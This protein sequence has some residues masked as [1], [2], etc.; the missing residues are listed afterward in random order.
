M[1]GISLSGRM[2]S[3]PGP[4]AAAFMADRHNS[5][6]AL[7]GPVGGG[8]TVACIHDLLTNAA[9]MPACRD[10]VIRFRSVAIRDT[11]DRL[12]KTTIATWTQ[13]VPK[14]LG[15]WVGGGGRSATHTLNFEVLRGGR[16]VPVEFEIIFAAIGDQAAEDFCRGFEVTAC[17]LN[18]M[19]RLSPDVLTHIMGRI[20]RYPRA[21]MMPAGV[22]YREFVIGDL[23]AP[24]IDDWFYRLFEETRP[25]GYA[26]YKQPSGLSPQAENIQNLQAGY[27]E[28]LVTANV[29]N[30]KWVKRFVHAAYGPSDEGEPVYSEYSDDRHL[31]RVRLEPRKGVPIRL[32]VD[33]GIQRPAGV[34]TQWLPSGQWRILGEVVPGRM[35]AKRFAGELKRWM[36]EN[37]P[38]FEIA[39]A[40]CDPAGFAGGDTE[41]GELA[42]AETVMHELGVAVLPAPSNEIGLRLDAVRE[43]L[44]YQIDGQTPALLLSSECKMLRKGFASHY[45]YARQLVAGTARYSDKPEKNDFSHCHDALQ[46]VLLGSKGR[47]GVVAGDGTRKPATSSMSGGCTVIKNTTRL[48]G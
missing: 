6:R 24:D 19:D 17:W 40:F 33:A 2:F 43:E 14:D 8:K 32:G 39:Q 35:G 16:K 41:S 18:E 9:L 10:G 11:Y 15:T 25:E 30:P 38:G 27:Y 21:E 46:Y 45:R 3:A 20:G 12:E 34:F 1:T 42:W 13:W 48:F 23:N 44:T 26:I 7:L 4:V 47:Y 31:S 22:K 5:V 29:N 37:A 36:T 28:R